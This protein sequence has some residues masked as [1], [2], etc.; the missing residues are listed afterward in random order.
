MVNLR[1]LLVVYLLILIL[2]FNFV[3]HNIY[4]LALS[5]L[6]LLIIAVCGS[7]KKIKKLIFFLERGRDIGNAPHVHYY[8][9]G[10]KM[11]LI[12]VFWIFQWKP[13]AN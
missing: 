3:I 7:S 9:Y 2:F 6:A 11:T 12:F 1:K 4:N 5:F 10:S 13:P 8:P